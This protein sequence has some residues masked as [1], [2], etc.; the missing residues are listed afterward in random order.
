M[1]PESP[2]RIFSRIKSSVKMYEYNDLFLNK[3]KESEEPLLS[4]NANRF[5]LFPIQYPDIWR[6]YKNH[7]NAF[8]TAE[9]ID[10]TSDKEDWD[11][12]N[13]NEKYFIENILAF[14]AGSDGIV[15]E[16]LVKN[17]CSEVTLP[18]ARCFYAF[19]AM[20]ENIHCVVGETKILTDNGFFPIRDLEDRT[21]NVWNGVEFS[22]VSVRFTGVQEIYRVSLSNGMELF[23]SPGHQWL[24]Q[25]GLK[26]LTTDLRPSDVIAEYSIPYLEFEAG[27]DDAYLYGCFS[28]CG[29]FIDRDHACLFTTRSELLE[30]IEPLTWHQEGL[31]IIARVAVRKEDVQTPINY[32]RETRLRWL[33]GLF[34]A[35]GSV[36]G[37]ILQC[38]HHDDDFL[39]EVQLLLLTLN[40]Q[41][42][43]QNG[44]FMVLSSK[45]LYELGFSPSIIDASCCKNMPTKEVRI[46]KVDKT[47][48][49]EKT[50]CFNE[51]RR[52]MGVF[53]GV[54]TCQS[55]VY[56]QM[57]DTFIDDPVK[58]EKLF[59]GI[60][61]IPC[62]EKKANWALNWIEENKGADNFAK[63][64]FA[65]G[66]VEG[67]FFSG[68]FCAIFW[69]KERGLMV[70]TLGKS[71][72]WI[73]RD[74][75]L[76][77][78]FAILLY[79]YVVNKINEVEAHNIMHQAVLIEEEFICESLP[80]DLIGMNNALMK[81]Y[82]RYCAD[83]LLVQFGYNKLYFDN[84]PFPFMEKISVDGKT[85]FFEQRVSEYS[86]SSM[87]SQHMF[88]LENLD[89]EVF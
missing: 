18:E 20:M 47:F 41:S 68:S 39:R 22:P 88:V 52:H 6:A 28:G 73:A 5:S 15:L 13:K 81:Q 4:E 7:K 75:G 48:R 42:C 45:D 30:H 62:I 74:E 44:R 24:L 86:L 23:C 80:V 83:R 55:E 59:Q 50:F 21:V 9:E 49:S 60:T 76:H 32:S 82:I 56:A 66:I 78:E 1:E 64:L 40:I 8:W 77:T 33:E 61:K 26:T 31:K 12:L 25:N 35:I 37:G 67:L 51:P 89:D 65:F 16:N 63:R 43:I 2:S 38:S 34:D 54:L 36:R 57:I 10:F 27:L 53:N 29:N 85:N 58:K 84:N 14:F 87:S 72:E 11:K 19:Q 70:Q 46:S 17:F 79:K 3:T 69:L 71:N